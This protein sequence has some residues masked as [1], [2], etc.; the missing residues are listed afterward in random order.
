MNEKEKRG[1]VSWLN[2][3]LADLYYSLMR[4]ASNFLVL[5]LAKFIRHSCW[6][7]LDL[8]CDVE[9]DNDKNCPVS[10][11]TSSNDTRPFQKEHMKRWWCYYNTEGSM[12]LS[13]WKIGDS[14]LFILLIDLL[15]D[16]TSNN[17]R[18][19]SHRRWESDRWCGLV[20]SI[21]Q[22]KCPDFLTSLIH[23]YSHLQD[24]RDPISILSK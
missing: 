11:G 8:L 2:L 1:I 19:E 9:L 3:N 24:D 14:S 18:S 13:I 21:R 15:S 20:C 10:P 16:P 5:V 23:R 12:W 4:E 22:C 17:N 6:L 7:T